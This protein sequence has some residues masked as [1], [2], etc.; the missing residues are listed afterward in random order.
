MGENGHV[1]EL[2]R[3]LAAAVPAEVADQIAAW[4]V[5]ADREIVFD[6]WLDLGNTSARVAVVGLRGGG[7]DASKLILKICPPD[8]TTAREPRRH[9]EALEKSPAEFTADHLVRQPIEPVQLLS[10]WWLLFQEIAGGSLRRVHPLFALVDNVKLPDIAS[11]IVQ[12]LLNKWNPSRDLQRMSLP[13]F[14]AANLGTRLEPNGPIVMWANEAKLPL[15]EWLSLNDRVLPN[16]VV[17]AQTVLA[18]DLQLNAVL[19]NAHGDLHLQNILVP[20]APLDP[21]HFRLIDLSGYS[22]AAPLAR[23][24]MHLLLSAV[25]PA[26]DAFSARQR[27]ELLAMLAALPYEDQPPVLVLQ[28]HSRLARHVFEAG[29]SSVAGAGLADDWSDQTAVA[30]SATALLFATLP[31]LPEEHQR[32][33]LGLAAAALGNYLER[34][35]QTAPGDVAASAT[36]GTT[37]VDESAERVADACDYF[38][39]S[40][41]TIAI[42]NPGEKRE[43]DPAL[44]AKPDWTLVVDFDPA[45]D[46]DGGHAAARAAGGSHRLVTT[47]QVAT[48]ARG[49][50][51]WFAAEG[52]DPSQR[53][54]SFLD[55][56][57][58][59]R[60]ALEQLFRSLA[61][62]T[63]APVTIVLLGQPTAR[64][65]VVVEEALN[66]FDER[67]RLVVVS[68]MDG[69]ELRDYDPQNLAE[70]PTTVLT[71]LPAGRRTLEDAPPSVPGQDRPVVLS[72]IE[73]RWFEEV[74]ELL[75]SSVGL[76]A[77]EQPIA[78]SFFHGRVIS[79]FELNL[80][81][82]LP[83]SLTDS[84][85]AR[86]RHDLTERDTYRISLNHYPGA[87]GT[88]VARRV[89]WALH[90]DF[91]TV[92]IR[93]AV[94]GQPV[95]DR[96]RELARVT[97]LPVFA[98]FELTAD[99]VIERIYGDLRANSVA[100]VLLV[101][102]RR[103]SPP[104]NPGQRSFYLDRI[105]D[106]DERVVFARQFEQLAPDRRD[107]LHAI[108]AAPESAIPFLYALTAFEDA[109]QGI[110]PYVEQL[111]QG[112]SDRDIEVIVLIALAHRYAG[113][114]V[115]ADLFSH[116]LEVPASV[117]VDLE[118]RL[119]ED[120]LPALVCELDDEWRT[121][122]WLVAQ[123]ILRQALAPEETS[124]RDDWTTSLSVWALR[125]I[126]EAAAVY[127]HYVPDEL[128]NT[129]DRLF[130]NRDNQD[131]SGDERSEF[132]EL[133]EAI[134]SVNGR[135]EVLRHLAENF[136][137]NAHYWA[138]LGRLL[139][140]RVGDYDEALSCLNRATALDER[141]AAL[142]HMRGMIYRRRARDLIATHRQPEEAR[143]IEPQVMELTDLA[144]G[145]FHR[146]A[147]LADAVEHPFVAIMQLAVSVLEFGRTASGSDSFGDLLARPAS[148]AFRQL[149]QEAEDALDR[150]REIRAGDELS[151]YAATAEAELRRIYDNYAAILQGWRNLLDRRDVIKAPI[152]RQLAR[153]YELRA[154]NWRSAS[155]DERRQ[156]ITLLDENLRDNPRDTRSLVDWLRVARFEDVSLD[157]AAELLSYADQASRD[158]LHYDYVIAALAVLGGRSPALVEYAIKQERSHERALGFPNRRYNYE[159]FGD[160][161][162][163]GALVH[164]S[165]LRSW[166]RRA[167]ADDPPLV[168]RVEGR[169]RTI[170][171]P[172]AGEL[173]LG[174]LKVFFTP[175]AAGFQAGRDENVRVTALIGFSYEG[176]QAWS[177][178]RA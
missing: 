56:R 154:G 178:R 158:M 161:H 153:V 26:L 103:T 88:T 132:S 177:V 116:L 112:A 40:R 9:R 108:S 16:P 172:Q 19:G 134:P 125:V 67:L 10:H 98:T 150:I 130:I 57:R 79:W 86:A 173:E 157:R 48:F 38:S 156:A 133:V 91:P 78:D 97:G 68:A 135:A 17:W 11:R 99:A 124:G 36:V 174:G 52:L 5:E 15:S 145:D 12:A 101:I 104:A 100:A 61:R 73:R 30:L 60:P 128:K 160:G 51:T 72:E 55:W 127:G 155:R 44:L 171:R 6:Q 92:V 39:G 175:S 22:P 146:S 151:R 94:D 31:N 143:T 96:L 118:S 121:L 32:W 74:G 43:V 66:I 70:D 63:S 41:V 114:A 34:A 120:V 102:G 4:Q 33:F 37:P 138:H 119:N 139:S 62:H 13:E 168:R 129:L 85:I 3:Q 42:A 80:A 142:F 27:A 144:L 147:Q 165:D 122:H 93:A 126:D 45:T 83:R 77:S 95:A 54:A 140:Y 162:G 18:P 65:R 71:G 1:T 117:A 109:F 35:G 167:D 149:L 76:I 152:R 105:T 2:D 53:I 8:R 110:R 111:L 169:I 137:D 136:S 81:I 29:L 113:T 107:E 115:A 24:P 25:L 89:A 131:P 164:H 47:G 141:D 82:D 106:R 170:R 75:H 7:H 163:L 58:Q 46:E 84:I 59:T 50:T 159:W 28:G 23:D 87:G 148:A 90:N 166:N 20:M 123:E 49:T 176:P 14:F 69:S 21:E 64:A